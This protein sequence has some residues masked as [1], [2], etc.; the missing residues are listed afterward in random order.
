M[1][2]PFLSAY[3]NR[4]DTVGNGKDHFNEGFALGKDHFDVHRF[5]PPLVYGR[6]GTCDE[7]E[8]ISLARV[9]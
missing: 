9:F 7:G 6:R 4:D 1:I 5:H 8:G 2:R 3:N